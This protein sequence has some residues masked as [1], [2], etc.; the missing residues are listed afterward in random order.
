MAVH[1]SKDGP[2]RVTV[3]IGDYILPFTPEALEEPDEMAFCAAVSA[4]EGL[5]GSC[6]AH[7]RLRRW[8]YR[9]GLR[10]LASHIR[11]AILEAQAC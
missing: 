4:W 1:L 3:H 8:L 10:Q 7:G 11:K 5:R 6:P 2:K 9:R